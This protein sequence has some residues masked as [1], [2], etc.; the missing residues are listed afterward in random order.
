MPAVRAEGCRSRVTTGSS[1]A[2][3]LISRHSV[4]KKSGGNVGIGTTNPTS[5]IYVAG[6]F[7]ATGTKSATVNTTSFGQ[8]KL[9]ALES[10][11]V[12]FI[13]DGQSMLKNGEA[14]IYLEPIFKETIETE[15]YLV[16]L[17]PI[18]EVNGLRVAEKTKDYFVVKKLNNGKSNARFMWQIS[19]HRKGY[20]NVRLEQV[21]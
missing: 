10:P 12:K 8:R 9:Y 5:I 19:A 7:T 4:W 15:N 14:I 13:D 6:T 1:F 21:Q 11:E 17:T 2:S 16:Q 18:D 20:G 3:G